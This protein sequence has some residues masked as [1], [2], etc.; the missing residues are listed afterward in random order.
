MTHSEMVF[1]RICRNAGYQTQR[2]VLQDRE[3]VPTADFVVSTSGFRLAAE[4]EELRPNKDDLQRIDSTR[5]GKMPA[6]GSTIGARSRQHIRRAARQLKPYSVHGIPLLV[7]LYNNV[8]LAGIRATH[9]MFHLE[10]HDIDAAMYGDRTAYISIATCAPTGRDRNA[11]RRT[12]TAKEK[13]YISAV[14]VISDHDDGTMTFY[15][16]QFANVPLKPPA[17]RGNNFFHFQKVPDEPWKW[18]P[19]A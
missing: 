9:P 14:A 18:V 11:G 2:P 8:Q 13:K 16:N 4:V 7:V 12:C 19:L 15:H 3:G 10:S 17:F 6:Y 1:E 5:R